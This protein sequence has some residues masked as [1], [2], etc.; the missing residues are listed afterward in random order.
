MSVRRDMGDN[1]GEKCIHG[2]TDKSGDALPN[3][4]NGMTIPIE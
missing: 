1:K 3:N 4:T 2:V